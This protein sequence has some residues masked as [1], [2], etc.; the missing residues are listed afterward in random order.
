MGVEELLYWL[1][2]SAKV[3]SQGGALHYIMQ[4]ARTL[5]TI[6]VYSVLVVN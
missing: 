6:R 4:P 2:T 3:S 1:L 5:H